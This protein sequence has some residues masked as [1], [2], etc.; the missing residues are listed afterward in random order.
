MPVYCSNTLMRV[1]GLPIGKLFNKFLK[2]GKGFDETD[3]ETLDANKIIP[4]PREIRK[5][6]KFS[7]VE[8]TQR[9]LG[10][11]GKEEREKQIIKQI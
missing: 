10:K 6:M 11:D 9:N 8:W 3:K 5:P 4:I 1:D 2:K 7:T